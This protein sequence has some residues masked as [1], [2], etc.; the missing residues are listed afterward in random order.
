[1]ARRPGRPDKLTPEVQAKI[2]NAMAAGNYAETSAQAAGIDPRT[3]YNWMARGEAEKAGKYFQFFRAVKDADARAEVSD[4]AVIHMDPSW[5]ARAWV[6]ERR[7]PAKW[8]RRDRME[9]SGAGGEPFKI[10]VEHVGRDGK[11]IEG[12]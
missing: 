9:V 5:Q 2:V 1:M 6:R 7:H 8:G 11:V 4:I 10:I 3:F 12:K